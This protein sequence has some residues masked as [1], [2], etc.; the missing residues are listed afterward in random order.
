[1][2]VYSEHMLGARHTH[3]AWMTTRVCLDCGYRGRELQN[4]AADAPIRCP[5]CGADLYS[6]RAR[7]YAEMEG[8]EI[9]PDALH[10][11]LVESFDPMV[12]PIVEHE[13]SA[14]GS[15]IIA[16]LRRSRTARIS[17]QCAVALLASAVLVGL[18]ALLGM[19]LGLTF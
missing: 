18:G 9:E 11:P 6:R 14:R 1:M 3:G 16:S 10:R 12:D 8:I 4:D 7:S 5:I 17:L 19:T 2:R 15:R 13:R